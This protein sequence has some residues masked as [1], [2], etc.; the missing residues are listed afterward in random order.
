MLLGV[1]LETYLRL[2]SRGTTSKNHWQQ[3]LL[4]TRYENDMLF[5]TYGP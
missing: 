1:I 3:K 5:V 4:F 2:K